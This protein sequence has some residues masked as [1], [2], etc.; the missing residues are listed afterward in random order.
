M[1]LL[2]ETPPLARGRLPTS[3]SPSGRSEKHPR[4]RG[5][6]PRVSVFCASSSETPPLA[7][8]RL[9]GRHPKSIGLRNTPACAGKTDE[10]A[11]HDRAIEKHPR[12]R[13]E[14]LPCGVTS[15][16]SE[17]T[18]PLARGRL[19]CARPMP[20]YAGN[21]PACAGKTRC[22]RCRTVPLRKHPRL[23][24]EDGT[25]V[26]V[27]YAAVGN[28]PA[29]AGK[30][31]CS[32]ACRR[33]GG[34]HPRLRGED[35]GR[36][37]EDPRALETPPLARGRRK[38]E[39]RPKVGRG[40]T[41]ACAGKTPIF[42]PCGLDFWKHPRLRGEDRV[43]TPQGAALSETPPLARGRHTLFL[44]GAQERGNTPACAGKTIHGLPR[45]RT[46]RETP[47]LARGRLLL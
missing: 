35:H 36:S 42:G 17:E 18:P 19:K 11:A 31:Q 32:R 5:E 25:H 33:E 13:G 14:D 15:V 9:V 45:A 28:T 44:K 40:N 23:R 29:C 4:L 16:V 39:R 47:P 46:V 41:P 37:C 3:T 8:G 10:S 12:L 1:E 2:E 34:K 26:M 43:T 21:T 30:T 6:D 38:R 7:R 27:G 24:G 22:L 20:V